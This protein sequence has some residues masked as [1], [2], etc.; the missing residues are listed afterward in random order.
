[1]LDAREEVGLIEERRY[2]VG[3]EWQ[4]GM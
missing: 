3:E 1:V 2:N 4:G